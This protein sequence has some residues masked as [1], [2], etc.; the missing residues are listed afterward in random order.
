[1]Q[2]A[3]AKNASEAVSHAERTSQAGRLQILQLPGIKRKGDTGGAG[4][5][6]QHIHQ[7]AGADI[8]GLHRTLLHRG[9]WNRVGIHGR[10]AGGGDSQQADFSLQTPDG[11]ARLPKA[12]FPSPKRSIK[13]TH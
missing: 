13:K 7:A 10:G 4:E 6:G 12:Y 9:A 5:T 11:L 8:V 2:A 1:M 3:P